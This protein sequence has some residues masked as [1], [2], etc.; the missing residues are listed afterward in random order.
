MKEKTILV[1]YAFSGSHITIRQASEKK[2]RMKENKKYSI[3]YYNFLPAAAAL[4]N[5][6]GQ[7]KK[8]TKLHNSE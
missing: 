5:A 7:G 6:G 1:E 8:L 2:I 4:Y 3:L